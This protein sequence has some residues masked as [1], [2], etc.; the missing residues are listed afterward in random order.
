MESG[1]YGAS[2]SDGVLVA[3][4]NQEGV[5]TSYTYDALDRIHT[6][7][8]LGAPAT[9]EFAAQA[10]IVTTYFYDAAGRTTQE[11]T[12]AG[13]LALTN[14]TTYDLAGRI[15]RTRSPDGLVTSN[16][17]GIREQTTVLPNGATEVT[18][19]Y[20]DGKLKERTGTGVV[21]E[22][23]EYLDPDTDGFQVARITYGNPASPRSVTTTIDWLGHAIRTERPH[24]GGI[25]TIESTTSYNNKG[26]ITETGRSGELANTMFDYDL[27][28]RQHVGGLDINGDGK[29]GAL[30]SDRLSSNATSYVFLDGVWWQER[31]DYTW[32]DWNATPTLQAI[33]RIALFDPECSCAINK[34]VTIDIH[35]NTTTTETQTNPDTKTTLRITTHSGFETPITEVYYNGRLQRTTNQLGGVTTY[36]LR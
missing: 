7:T 6:Q 36:I 16:S 21:P 17:Y 19:Y 27:L 26:Q 25:G 22:F 5:V 15:V 3:E 12:S 31:R 8:R 2:W 29:L 9:A 4:T 11:V 13:A 30:S 35:G 10:D 33:N 20:L 18:R 14:S 24:V 32:P 1:T 34:T 28:G 23:Y